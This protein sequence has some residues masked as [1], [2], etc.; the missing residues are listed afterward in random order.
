[1]DDCHGGEDEVGCGGTGSPDYWTTPSPPN[2]FLCTSGRLSGPTGADYIPA[3]WQCDGMDDCKE[4]E[5]E[6]GC[7]YTPAPYDWTTQAPSECPF[8]CTSGRESGP[9]GDDCIPANWQCDNYNDCVGG[10]DEAGCGMT[11]SNPNEC[12]S[13]EFVCHSGRESGPDNCIPMRWQC[14]GMDD[15]RDGEDENGCSSYTTVSPTSPVGGNA[16]CPFPEAQF[17]CDNGRC[18]SKYWKCDGDNDC[19]DWSDERDCDITTPA[20]SVN[21]CNSDQFDCLDGRC[22][23]LTWRCDEDNDCSSGLDEA[24]C[25]DVTVAPGVCSQGEFRCGNGRCIQLGWKCDGEDDCR[26]NSDEAGC[27]T[28]EPADCGNLQDTS[29]NKSCGRRFF[30]QDIQNNAQ[31]KIVGG[32]EAVRGAYPYQ[33][34]LRRRGGHICGGTIID[35][36]T[37]IT[38][39]HCLGRDASD[40]SIVAGEHSV[41]TA[42]DCA[43]QRIDVARTILHPAYD[44]RTSANDIAILKLQKNLEFNRYVQ[45]ACL[46]AEDYAYP[47]G[48]DVII[49][50]WGA[51][52]EG[53][54]SPNILNVAYVPLISAEDCQSRYRRYGYD[55]SADMVCAAFTAGGVDTCQGD[56]G[57]PL[58]AGSTSAT[59]GFKLVG[60]VS[61]GVGCARPGV[62]GVY[63]RV[64]HFLKWIANNR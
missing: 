17:Q 32:I 28:I 9:T 61:W 43:E 29:S 26:D 38:A 25:T 4:G 3:G 55:I 46:P 14:D 12:D 6:T 37:I 23:P 15:C 33:I 18:I 40:Y 20:T 5:D 59:S 22:I 58:V 60:V 30:T 45:P 35:E 21:E 11:T 63:A 8:L 64:T 56:S 16:S 36:N 2:Q 7:T 42:A 62:P 49:S 54:G 1:M 24:N 10:E 48:E 31:S 50:G 19:S 47:P 27:P 44:D 52:T 34:S 41:R 53:G 39:A 57:G 51:L 13:D